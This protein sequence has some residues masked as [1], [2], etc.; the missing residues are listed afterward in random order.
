MRRKLQAS[1]VLDW[2]EGYTSHA[3]LL[4]GIVDGLDGGGCCR[5]SLDRTA[6]GGCPHMSSGNSSRFAI[7]AWILK[8]IGI[9]SN[10]KRISLLR[11]GAS[12]GCRG[13]NKGARGRRPTEF[14]LCV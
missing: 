3:G 8:R 4:Q 13:N 14:R 10:K 9:R 7:A 5:A 1:C 12:G 2:L 11:D 6:E